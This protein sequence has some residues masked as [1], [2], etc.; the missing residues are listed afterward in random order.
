MKTKY[1]SLNI[2][3][4]IDVRT[5]KM[6]NAALDFY[7]PLCRMERQVSYRVNLSPLNYIQIIML[8][9]ILV[10]LTFSRMEAFALIWP[11]LVWASFEI[12]RRLLFKRD[13]PCPHCGFDATWYKKDVKMARKL[14]GEFWEKKKNSQPESKIS[15]TK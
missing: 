14:V 10:T 2:H 4:E 6:K 7:C 9:F 11:F 1:Q 12:T 13:V 5:Y 8:S 15:P 3:P